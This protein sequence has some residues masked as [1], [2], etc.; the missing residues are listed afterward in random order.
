M[1]PRPSGSGVAGETED[2]AG[3]SLLFLDFD[4]VVSARNGPRFGRLPTLEAWLRKRSTVDVVVASSWREQ[5]PLDKLR[6]FFAED[7]QVRV[8]GVTPLIKPD[9]WRQAEAER[10][11]L[12]PIRHAEVLRWLS[13]SPWPGRRWAALDDQAELYKPG[14][15]VVICDPRVGLT[16]REL[17]ELDQLLEV[18]ASALGCGPAPSE[19]KPTGRPE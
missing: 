15:P 6:D 4:G 3:M 9:P 13:Q 1:S 2:P 7:L 17:G 5:F 14:A 8:I 10:P 19:T 12:Q 11:P 18:G 16:Q